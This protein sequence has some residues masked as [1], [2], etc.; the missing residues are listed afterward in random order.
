V[1]NKKYENQNENVAWDI[2]PQK[3]PEVPQKHPEVSRFPSPMEKQNKKLDEHLWK[4][5][6]R[7]WMKKKENVVWGVVAQ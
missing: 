4:N 6:I 1:I 5:K 7:S 3:H 2:V